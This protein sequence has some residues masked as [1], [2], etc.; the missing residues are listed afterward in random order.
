M[1]EQ[2]KWGIRILKEEPEWFDFSSPN[3]ESTG[4]DFSVYIILDD[5]PSDRVMVRDSLNLLLHDPQRKAYIEQC[6]NEYYS[7]NKEM[8][9]SIESEIEN[10]NKVI[11]L[12]TKS[13][14]PIFNKTDTDNTLIVCE[15]PILTISV[16]QKIEDKTKTLYEKYPFR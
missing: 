1:I 14:A 16:E 2:N 8:F 10:N 4:A 11:I 7:N 6:K 5:L 13:L 9:S 15:R 3:N 12:T